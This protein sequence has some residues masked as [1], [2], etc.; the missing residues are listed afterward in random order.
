MIEE[1]EIVR[2][3]SSLSSYSACSLSLSDQDDICVQED[4]KK[5]KVPREGDTFV[6]I[7]PFLDEPDGRLSVNSPF[8]SSRWEAE[9]HAFSHENMTFDRGGV[10]SV[11]SAPRKP[12][13][14][15]SQQEN[16]EKKDDEA[17]ERDDDEDEIPGSSQQKMRE[18]RRHRSVEARATRQHSRRC[19]HSFDSCQGSDTPKQPQRRQRP[20]LT[21]SGRPEIKRVTSFR[22]PRRK[23]SQQY[24]SWSN[25]EDFVN[26]KNTK[27][28]RGQQDAQATGRCPEF[29]RGQSLRFPRNE[30][31][32]EN[33]V[34]GVVDKAM[35]KIR[36][37]GGRPA[38]VKSQ[39]LKMPKR[40]VSI[41]E[42]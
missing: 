9:S 39:S 8:A 22:M 26:N 7:I 17:V 32:R 15:I 13:R 1:V 42:E 41:T 4:N 38:F 24:A 18:R 28:Q 31:L 10:S 20:V 21:T 29:K 5:K 6:F 19:P 35:D 34:D 3:D 33:E 14:R 37:R 40:R 25:F 12:T 30:S 36:S 16:E 23:H 11:A 27:D 2:C